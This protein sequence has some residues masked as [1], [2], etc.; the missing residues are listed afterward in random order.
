[1]QENLTSREQEIFNLLLD[2][3]SPKEIAYK[4]HVSSKAVDYHQGNLY[5]KLSVHSIQELFAKY[6]NDRLK[7]DSANSTVVEPEAT[8]PANK[9]PK[10]KRLWLLISAGALVLA[11]LV[12]LSWL[13][14][15]K[16]KAPLFE[17]KAEPLFTITLADNEPW[18]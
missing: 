6:S 9:Q 16:P 3:I 18:G 10:S 12:F 7:A 8:S 14:F 15:I 4:L 17:S 1:M 5:G 2:G 11:V 13:F